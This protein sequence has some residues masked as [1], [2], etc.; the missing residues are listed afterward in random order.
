[1]NL[2]AAPHAEGGAAASC[3]SDWGRN[4]WSKPPRRASCRACR[5]AAPWL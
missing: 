3:L 5:R 2:A 1:M 4:C